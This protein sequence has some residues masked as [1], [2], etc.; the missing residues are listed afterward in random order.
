MDFLQD[1]WEVDRRKFRIAIICAL[2]EE[3]TAVEATFDE[4]YDAASYGKASGDYNAYSLGRIGSHDV[5]LTYLPSM[6]KVSSAN[7]GAGLRSSFINVKLSLLVG[8]CGGVPFR[9][10]QDG[11]HDIL[12]G[13]VI[14]GTGVVQYDFGRQYEDG[15]VQ[16]KNTI[17]DN[18]ARL[19][20]EIRASLHKAQALMGRRQMQEKVPYYINHTM[21]KPEFR[22]WQAPGR[23]RDVLFKS[24]YVHKHRPPVFC[25]ACQMSGSNTCAQAR[26]SSC[27]D[28]ACSSD[29]IVP[30]SRHGH[31]DGNELMDIRIHWGVIASGDSVIKS[32]Q[33]RDNIASNEGVI[34]F[35]MEGAGLWEASP[36]IIVK[37]V[38]DYADSHKHKGWQRYAAVTAAAVA[39]ALLT[40]DLASN[41]GTE[42]WDGSRSRSPFMRSSTMSVS[43]MRSPRTSLISQ[44]AAWIV[45]FDQPDP[46]VGRSTEVKTIEKLLSSPQRC[47]KTAIEGLGGMGKSRLAL[48][49]VYSTKEK[50]PERSI[51]WVQCSD[52]STFERDY[53]KIAQYF[54]LPGANDLFQDPKL[55][56]KQSLDQD[57]GRQWLLILDSADDERLWSTIAGANSTDALLKFIPRA[58]GGSILIT[59]RTHRVAVT[60]AQRNVVKLSHLSLSDSRLML[61]GLLD[62]SELLDNT[63]ATSQLL[64]HLTHLPLAIVQAA[65]YINQNS[66]NSIDDYLE[67]W[68]SGEESEIISTLR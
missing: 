45:P 58:R 27:T 30:R 40:S 57:D 5:V 35:E 14:I 24:D 7:A 65:A 42:S 34:A 4:F 49:V 26:Q 66:L 13:D 41:L 50:H 67:I 46:L 64:H 25:E 38:C 28:L 31:H 22:T 48:E 23:E 10:D 11:E 52:L 61:H 63:Q 18:L 1:P 56:V 55:M 54:E 68:N 37:G 21:S 47:G 17:Q 29:H 9:R 19:P 53:R 51:F 2:E 32:G 33:V 44:P 36:V 20:P 60:I 6:G 15:R 16:R 39:K 43:P 59:T 8:I 12:L 3:S 62:E